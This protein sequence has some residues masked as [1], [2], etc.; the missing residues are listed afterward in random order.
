VAADYV[1]TFAARAFGSTGC[2]AAPVLETAIQKQCL[3]WLEAKRIFAWRNNN[4][5]V[6]DPRT[7]AFRFHGLRGV[8]D[9]LGI[10]PQTVDTVGHGQQIFGNLLAIEVK[11]PKKHPTA[12]QQAFLDAITERGG[13]GICVHSVEELEQALAGY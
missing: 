8:S 4:A 13:I 6:C 3:D 5:G 11:Q 2:Y 1:A 10:F 9:I 7:G 12:D